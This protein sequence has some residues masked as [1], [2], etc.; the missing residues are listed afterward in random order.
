MFRIELAGKNTDKIRVEWVINQLQK[1][2]NGKKILDAGAGELK[3]K[4]Y[5]D[6]LQYF[7][8]DFGQYDGTGD[9]A[10]Q[11]G[12]WDNT[13]LDIISDI[14]D[15]PVEDKSFDVILCTEVLEH[16]PDAVKA[17][18]E[19]NRILKPGGLLLLTAPFASL[20]HFAPYHYCGYNKYWYQYHLENLNFK[21]IDLDINGSW[22]SFLAQELRRSRFV[23]KNY[24]LN[25]LS[26]IF[27]LSVYPILLLLT[28]LNTF[29]RGSCEL[30]CFGFMVSARKS[31]D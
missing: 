23:T 21:I 22:F 8:Q 2:D 3:F 15:I 6:H 9:E 13:K 7:A 31:N 28:I 10:L 12:S 19:F 30:L 25:F 1:I 11:T 5:C 27:R 17:L 18:N 20:T 29:D 16:L 4:K 26:I 24:S 14:T